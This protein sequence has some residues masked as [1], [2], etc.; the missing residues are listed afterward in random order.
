MKIVARKLSCVHSIC[1]VSRPSNRLHMVI[2]RGN[3]PY[4]SVNVD[5]RRPHNDHVKTQPTARSKAGS[6]PRV[7]G[8]V[9]PGGRTVA[10]LRGAKGGG[11]PEQ[12][13]HIPSNTWLSSLNYRVKRMDYPSQGRIQSF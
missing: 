3:I 11:H 6:T 10:S 5:E 12:K 2:F 8:I 1:I 13:P 9:E 4:G 7:Q